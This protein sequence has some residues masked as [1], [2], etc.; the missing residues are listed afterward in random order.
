MLSSI[1]SPLRCA[2]CRN[3]CVFHDASLWEIPAPLVAVARDG[4][5]RPGQ[6]P[7]R[8]SALDESRGCTLAARDKPFECSL[9]PLRVMTRNGRTLIAA[10]RSCPAVDAAFLERAR[11]LLA[12]GLEQKIIDRLRVQ[13]GIARPWSDNYTMLCDITGPAGLQP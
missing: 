5:L 8:C 10:A 11:A 6:E 7:W 13:P 1:L 2:A 12:A 9:W 4:S 3:C